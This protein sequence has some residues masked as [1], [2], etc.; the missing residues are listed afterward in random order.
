MT[1][2]G[3]CQLTLETDHVEDGAM[4]PAEDGGGA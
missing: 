3:T 1:I 4:V 2:A